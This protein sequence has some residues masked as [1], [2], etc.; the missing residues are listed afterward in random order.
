MKGTFIEALD[1]EVCQE[2]LK[3]CFKSKRTDDTLI[4]CLESNNVTVFREDDLLEMPSNVIGFI[5]KGIFI[6]KL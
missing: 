6:P 4:I 2:I 1:N 5:N 3:A